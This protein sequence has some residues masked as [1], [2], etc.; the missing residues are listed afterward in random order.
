MHMLNVWMREDGVVVDKL[1]LTAN[2]AYVPSANGPAQ[3]PTSLDFNNWS[4]GYGLSGNP[5]DDT[6]GDGVANIIEYALGLHP[7]VWDANPVTFNQYV[8]NGKTYLSLS[9]KR[10]P[11]VTDVLIEGLSAGTL[12][13]PSAWSTDTT[14]LVPSVAPV[15]T[16]RDTVPIETGSQRFIRLRFTRQ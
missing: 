4:L 3:S 10:N 14:S 7:M 9:V 1:I 13:S 11:T 6:D 8:D 15:L 16:V 2:A 5:T 12:T